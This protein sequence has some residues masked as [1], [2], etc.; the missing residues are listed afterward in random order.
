MLWKFSPQENGESD[1]CEP[2]PASSLPSIFL[3]PLPS[4]HTLMY[5][6]KHS[7]LMCEQKAL[8]SHRHTL[9]PNMLFS[10]HGIIPRKEI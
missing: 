7:E 1:N 10:N 8:T 5:P 3:L 4:H 6:G 2:T 9:F